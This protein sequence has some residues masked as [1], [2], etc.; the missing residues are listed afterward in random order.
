MAN[1]N[2]NGVRGAAVREAITKL[3]SDGKPHFRREIH[4]LCGPSNIAVIRVH[5]TLIRRTLPEDQLIIAGTT[6][7]GI[8]YQ[9]VR[10]LG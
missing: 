4:D 5:I 6:G 8:Y 2:G 1:G 7:R 3:L 9:W 10:V